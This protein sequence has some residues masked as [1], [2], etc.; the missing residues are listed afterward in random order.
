MT[1]R[2]YYRSFF[3]DHIRSL[4]PYIV[5]NNLISLITFI[6]KDAYNGDNIKLYSK[7]FFL[8]R[9]NF[10]NTHRL[11]FK[12]SLNYHPKG[13]RSTL[14][15]VMESQLFSLG[16]GNA[17]VGELVVFKDN[18]VINSIDKELTVSTTIKSNKITGP[19]RYLKDINNNKNRIDIGTG[20]KKNVRQEAKKLSQKDLD[21]LI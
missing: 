2:I 10:C 3:Y 8:Y 9:S 13:E 16:G 21:N 12:H 17:E 5:F 15:H 20:I 11:S 1:R 18:R 19:A 4:L 6:D 7:T 14:R